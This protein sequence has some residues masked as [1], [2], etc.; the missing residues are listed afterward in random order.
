MLDT[1]P[2]TITDDPNEMALIEARL[3]ALDAVEEA[4][5]SD[6]VQ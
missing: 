3:A 2:V 1:K 4:D 6:K 5:D